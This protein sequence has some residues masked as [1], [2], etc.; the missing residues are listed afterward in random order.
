MKSIVL[1]NVYRIY[2]PFVIS[3]DFL[4]VHAMISLHVE[5]FVNVILVIA[6]WIL[7]VQTVDAMVGDAV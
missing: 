7:A 5:H 4:K 3:C 2:V 1:V 6:T